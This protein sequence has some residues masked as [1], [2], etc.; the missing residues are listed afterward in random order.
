MVIADPDI[1]RELSPGERVLWQGRPLGG[2]RFVPQDLLQFLFGLFFFGFSLFWL[3]AASGA[4]TKGNSAPATAFP[5]FGVP[6]VLMG[7]YFVCGRFVFEAF[8]RKYTEYAVTN[9]RVIIRSGILNKST[10]SIDYRK[11]SNIRLI[12]KPNNSGI[13]IFGDNDPYAV[14]MYGRF[15]RSAPDKQVLEFIPDAR[16]V[17]DLIRKSSATAA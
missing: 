13:I 2:L 7:F 16:S 9:Q 15:Q 11:I 4:M 14:Q 5:L 6:F 17:Y 10:R 1:Q 8:Q 3:Y 12:E